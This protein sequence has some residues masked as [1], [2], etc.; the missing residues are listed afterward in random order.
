VT[1]ED[2][3]ERIYHVFTFS[4]VNG[5]YMNRYLLFAFCNLIIL[6]WISPVQALGPVFRLESARQYLVM[7]D[8]V[9]EIVAKNG[10]RPL[11]SLSDRLELTRYRTIVH[12]DLQL[13]AFVDEQNGLGIRVPLVLSFDDYFQRRGRAQFRSLWRRYMLAHISEIK[14]AQGSQSLL[15]LDL[16]VNLPTFLGGGTPNFSI[17]GSQRI[18]MDMRSEWTDGLVST[19]TNRVSR[20]PNLSMKQQQQFTVNGTVGQKVSVTISQDSQA[21]SDLDNSISVRYEDRFD[22]GREGNGIIKRFEAGNI[23]LALE[24]AQFTGYTDQH[25]GLFGIKMESQFGGLQ[26]TTIISQEKAAGQAA[27]FQAGSQGNRQQIRDLDYRRRTYYFI[28]GDYRRNF[29]RRDV[30]G[31]HIADEDSVEIIRVFVAD[32]T[33][34]QDLANIRKAVAYLEPPIS[35]SGG[36]FSNPDSSNQEIERGDFRELEFN[37]FAVDRNLGY[38]VLNTP[39]QP[40]DALGI[41]YTTR[42]RLSG[43]RIEYGIVPEVNDQGIEA[44]LR[45]LKRRQENPPA[46][47][48]E[49]DPGKWGTWQYEWRNVYFLGTTDINPDGFELR[50]FKREAGQQDQDV[51]EQG[52]PYIQLLG[53]DRRGIDPGSTPDRLVDID[54][55][56]INFQRGD[57]IFPDLY[58]FSP[59]LSA[60]DNGLAYPTTQAS[61]LSEQ[62]PEIYTRRT[63]EINTNVAAFNKYYMEVEYKNRLAQYS[64]GRT[65]IIE[66][67]EVV[68]LNGR[69]LQQ[70]VDY[71]LLHEVGQI[72]FINQEALNPNADV[73]V[74]YQFAPFFQP[75]SNTLMGFQGRYEVNDRSWVR[76]TVL[77]R[78]D[79]SLDQKSRIGREVG[80]FLMWDFDARLTFKP[81]FMTSF[82]NLIPF[83]NR[84]DAESSLNISAELAQSIPNP[85]TRGD[86][87]IDDFEGSKE[88]TDL[89]VRRSG[90]VPASP[91][92]GRQ[93]NQRGRLIW[94]N[95]IEQVD[96]REIYPTREVTFR[97][98]VQHVLTMEYDPTLP[99]LRWGGINIDTPFI[100]EWSKIDP[101]A[102]QNR[103]A[104]VMRPMVGANIDQTRSKFIEIWVNGA[105]GELHLD[106]GSISEDVNGN[107]QF[108][109]EDDRTDGF[110]NNLIDQGEDIGVDG[111]TDD[112]EIG[113]DPTTLAA[114]PFDPVANPDPHRDNF[115]FD[116]SP[117]QNLQFDQ[118]DYNHING[119]EDNVN[120]PD[121]GRRPNTED[122]NNSGFIDTQNAYFQFGIHLSPDHA[123]TSLV[124][125]G[126]RDKT[127]WG[128]AQSWR[129]YRIP[130][131][132]NALNSTFINQI[133]TPSFALIEMVRLW[134]TNVD[135]PTRL[136]IASIQIVGNK[137]QEDTRGSIVDSVGNIIPSD[138]LIANQETFEVSVKNTFDNPGDYVSPP[139]AIVEFDRVTGVQ[140]R[141]QALVLNYTNLQPGHS[142]Q[143]FRTFFNEQDYTLYNDL[144]MFVYGS[145]NLTEDQLPEFFI[146]FGNGN[147]DYYEYRMRVRPGW[148]SQNNLNIVFN[149]LTV[150]KRETEFARL[151]GTFDDTTFTI[152]LADGAD[153]IVT[154]TA[155]TSQ[156][157]KQAITELDNNRQ[158]RVQG[159]PSL[160]RIRQMTVGVY[161]PNIYPLDK[162][163]IW[164]DELRASDV[165]RD[166]G[167]AGRVSIDADFA[168]FAMLR[169]TFQQVGSHYR[170]IGQPEAG[171]TS[172]LIDLNTNLQLEKFLPDNWGYAMPVRI[173]WRKDLRLPR[174]QVGSD[175]VLL[176]SDQRQEQ[177]TETLQRQF[178]IAYS[179]RSGSENPLVAWTLE[180]TR[181]NF[182]ASSRVSRTVTREDTTGNY[183]AAVTMD[184]TPRSQPRIPILRWTH[185]PKFISG[186]GFN[187]LPTQF[188][189]DA[190]IDR[191]KQTGVNRQ[192]NNTRQNR[193]IRNMNRNLRV[194]MN[195]FKAVTLDYSL[196]I[197]NDMK[198]DS[199]INLK[200]LNFG[201][202]TSYR[203]TFGID[204]RPDLASWLRPS[205]S[206][207]T[208]Y[209]ENRNPQLQIT[210]TSPDDRTINFS[211]RRTIRTNLNIDRMLSSAFGSPSRPSG[212][213]PEGVSRKLARGVRAFFGI[214]NP[215]NMNFTTDE[216]QNLFN[217]KSRPQFGYQLG[218]S[219]TP[220][221]Q[222]I[223]ADTTGGAQVITIQQNRETESVTFDVDTGFKLISDLSFTFRPDWRSS[224]TRS[225]NTNIEQR[226]LTWPQTSIRWSPN[227]RRMGG[228]GRLFRRIDLSSGYARRVDRQTNLNLAANTNL[229]G[230]AETKTT[231]TSLSPLIGVTLDWAI[232]L[233]LRGNY[234]TYDEVSRLGLSATDQ[235][236]QNR[237][238]NLAF[239]YRFNSGFQFFGHRLNG[240]LT[241]R[242]QVSRSSAQT[243]ISRDGN[244]FKPSN[245]QKQI[246]ISFRT[247]YQFSRH[248][249]GGLNLEWTNTEN[250]I[251]KEK[252]LLRSGGF[253]TEFQF[254]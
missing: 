92:D 115:F 212:D 231:S 22:D 61:G 170:Q 187:P 89:G 134:V 165:R 111:L 59:T 50:I 154:I 210:G 20:F 226:S 131:E 110:G 95:P 181:I 163:E 109:T 6:S 233:G 51:D 12:P 105:Q 229:V 48:N 239:D 133:G 191:Q 38:I 180:R 253:W 108:D 40:T 185:L 55:E 228:L 32:R 141:E 99:D 71:I 246:G 206:F 4:H 107:N 161:N 251:T 96:V 211:N 33:S 14:N 169:G 136:R 52:Q 97:D 27:T 104:G 73:T 250:A 162:G 227:V 252:R 67:S 147:S 24:N 196:A 138:Q 132:T 168:D 121:Q 3:I 116:Y 123:D 166:R 65:N 155:G 16:P 150:L 58:P 167:L 218:F 182:S 173:R 75:A 122:I 172:T 254:N 1:R 151:E 17:S 124:V 31:L 194:R 237:T 248:V 232:G 7:L 129:M 192:Y 224:N 25:S 140:N 146:R 103:W 86:G 112:Q 68:R 235:K 80:R 90:W 209:S 230:T 234:E 208:N 21:F 137:W 190:R 62:T 79:K 202:E 241:T 76:G 9:D 83:V 100:N 46:F 247:D 144:R 84:G 215:I 47:A 69:A 128:D 66:G 87:F 114:V 13:L 60:I 29:S 23:S 177:R 244:S 143:A 5:L 164:L 236:R 15:S 113:F 178:S 93:H 44:Q 183:Q 10:K 145:E 26:L 91:P 98:Q 78:S 171:N 106:L 152:K 148:D 197:T 49:D 175:I 195:P 18:Q 127:N 207:T 139:G 220:R 43:I 63:T 243:L 35:F 30:R 216:N 102:L 242:L 64:L 70:G 45:L 82:I 222:A 217:I 249:R 198:A 176:R 203:Q 189:M 223:A 149:D 88:E 2:V 179:K 205:Y 157:R 186:T 74:Q 11:R 201:P 245:G 125:G 56:L 199:T 193:F 221:F 158:Y 156:D 101:S 214:L 126:D 238:L 213:D 130:L 225:T 117:G 28:D 174:L 188:I 240:N 39:L 8:D 142:A 85:N 57:L 54:Y 159:T 37:E 160:S 72:R 77:Y 81:Q 42:H 219:N 19:A 204:Y 118:I 119:P 41:Y 200:D 153:R 34:R 120:D 184:L 36:I 94:Y 135:Q 53:L